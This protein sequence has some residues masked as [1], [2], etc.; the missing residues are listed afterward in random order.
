MA[1]EDVRWGSHVCTILGAAEG[2]APGKH[3]SQQPNSHSSLCQ[4]TLH[5]V[6][7]GPCLKGR[8]S[9]LQAPCRLL[10]HP[11]P[12]FWRSL[13]RCPFLFFSSGALTCFCA[14]ACRLPAGGTMA[15][16]PQPW[17]TGQ[18]WW[19]T[20]RGTT[21]TLQPWDGRWPPPR[22]R[23]GPPSRLWTPNTCWLCLVASLG[24]QLRSRGASRYLPV[25]SSWVMCDAVL[26]ESL[27]QQQTVLR[28]K[29][30]E[31]L[32]LCCL[33]FDLESCIEQFAAIPWRPPLR[34]AVV[35]RPHCMGSTAGIDL[36]AQAR[37]LTI[38]AGCAR[39]L[40]QQV[41]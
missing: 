7:C 33:A 2:K 18:C 28:G 21:P 8:V 20:T 10:Q 36:T 27:H 12:S 6:Q 1:L 37:Y 25:A 24:E 39:V 26:C 19:T 3:A 35:T 40:A 4:L 16:R 9:R 34:V 41:C 11:M 17:P 38:M 13:A 32:Q 29:A 15:T 14:P 31:M 5:S 30:T 22:S 23:P